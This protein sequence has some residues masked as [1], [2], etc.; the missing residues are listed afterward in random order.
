MDAGAPRAHRSCCDHGSAARASSSVEGQVAAV[1]GSTTQDHSHADRPSPTAVVKSRTSS[2][3]NQLL[4]GCLKPSPVV[5]YQQSWTRSLPPENHF[6]AFHG[7]EKTQL[8]QFDDLEE[9]LL[10]LSIGRY[11]NSQ[12]PQ[13]DDDSSTGTVD[14]LVLARNRLR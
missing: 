8:Y 2:P 9:I 3:G 4:K 1:C 14:S 13:T 11:S 10:A 12:D 5:G 6:Q 7:T